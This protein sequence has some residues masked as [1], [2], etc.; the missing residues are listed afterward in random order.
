MPSPPDNVPQIPV[1]ALGLPLPGVIFGSV[2]G[3]EYVIVITVIGSA[4]EVAIVVGGVVVAAGG[5]YL[6]WEAGRLVSDYLSER[7]VRTSIRRPQWRVRCSVHGNGTANHESVG[8]VET[9][10]NAGSANE[11][12]L[13]ARPHLEAQIKIQFGLTGFHTQHCNAVAI[14]GR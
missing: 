2:G 12:I 3:G 7:R 11:A 8:M 6:A 14:A 1:G 4:P 10:V 13:L 9:V 5:A